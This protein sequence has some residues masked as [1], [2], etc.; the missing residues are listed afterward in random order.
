MTHKLCLGKANTE[1]FIPGS[2]LLFSSVYI[3]AINKG[4]LIFGP[5]ELS[6][7]LIARFECSKLYQL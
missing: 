5:L 6:Q 2:A 7:T 3:V 4:L 1:T